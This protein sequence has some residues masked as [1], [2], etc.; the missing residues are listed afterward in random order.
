MA[1]YRPLIVLLRIGHCIAAFAVGQSSVESVAQVDFDAQ[2]LWVF[3][4]VV[5]FRGIAP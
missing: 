3:D 1:E 5:T 2:Q 4:E